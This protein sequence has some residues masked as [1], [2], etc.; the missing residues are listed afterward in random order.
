M[1]CPKCMG[2]GYVYA[3]NYDKRKEQPIDCIYCNNQG[4]VEINE[5]IIKELQDT[6]HEKEKRKEI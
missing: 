4:D 6:K 2:N 5:K 3:F 1:I